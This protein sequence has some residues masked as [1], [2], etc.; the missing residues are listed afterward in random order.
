M[1]P[2]ADADPRRAGSDVRDHDRGGGAR[3]AGHVVVLGKPEPPITQLLDVLRQLERPAQRIRRRRAS[4]DRARSSTEIGTGTVIR[5]VPR[6]LT[7][8]ARDQLAETHRNPGIYSLA[9]HAS[10]ST[11]IHQIRGRLARRAGDSTAPAAAR[12]CP[13]C[14]TGGSFGCVG[15]RSR[16]LRRGDPRRP[17]SAPA[18]GSTPCGNRSP[19]VF[20]PKRARHVSRTRMP[21]RCGM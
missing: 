14:G 10:R 13:R 5:G 7:A 4:G 20:T 16:R 6:V 2:A 21:S 12:H 1:P 19:T 8:H 15:A 17:A 3:D 11:P 18:A 9:N